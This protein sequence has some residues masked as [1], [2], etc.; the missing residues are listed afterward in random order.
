[1]P[2]VWIGW[3]GGDMEMFDRQR[4]KPGTESPDVPL[5]IP[6]SLYRQIRRAEKQYDKIQR[7]LL[8]MY[9]NECTGP[10]PSERPRR[11]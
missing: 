9:V 2:K 1:M 5:E 8:Q 6:A 11:L 4:A 10:V 7:A 3:D